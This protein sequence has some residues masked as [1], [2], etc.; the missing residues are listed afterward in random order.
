MNLKDNFSPPYILSSGDKKL[1]LA[2]PK[3]MGILNVTSDSFADGGRYMQ[4]DLAIEHA[5]QM[6]QDGADII[7]IGGE[8]SR[9]GSLGISEQEELE[10]VLPV[11]EKLRSE[12]DAFISVDTCK[13][14]VMH[15]VI[16]AGADM[17]ND[18]NALLSAGA[19]QVIQQSSVAV[20]L[21]HKKGESSTMQQN[22]H[23]ENVITEVKDFLKQR[24][25]DCFQ[26][27]IYHDRIIVDPGF[28]FGKSIQHN[29]AL[30]KNLKDLQDLGLPILVGWSRKATLGE[31]LKCLPADRLHGSLAAAVIAIINGANI[32]RV[33]DVK[34]TA[35]AL[36]VTAA[37]LGLTS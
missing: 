1:D 19:M 28:G 6:I 20:C 33:H 29:L 17:I 2:T 12:T 15:Q 22:P 31:I 30:L 7:D 13:A 26:A 36:K 35:D 21:M 16:Q 5:L 11:L 14:G 25:E 8:S 10:R 4:V 24:V 27:G 3:I 9:P 18:I 34:P 37:V 23:Y 32:L